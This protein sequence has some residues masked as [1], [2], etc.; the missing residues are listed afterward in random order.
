MEPLSYG[1]EGRGFL[2]PD[3]VELSVDT[4]SRS[5]N[6]VKDWNLN[7][8]CDVDK[9]ICGPSQEI[10]ESTGFLESGIADIFKKSAASN[11]C[12]GALSGEIGNG[13]M[14]ELGAMFNRSATKSCNPMSLPIGLKLD[15][16]TDYG[17]VRTS[18]SSKESSVLSSPESSLPTGE[19]AKR[20][21]L[22]SQFP[23]S[24]VRGQKEDESIAYR[25]VKSNQSL[26]R[27]SALSSVNSSLQGKRLRT[28][29]L[30]SEVPF[31][32]VHGC[33][34][35]LSSSKD[36]HKRHKVCDEHSKTA[37]VIVN[38]IEQR[39]C[40]QCSRF[41]LLAEFDEGKRSCRKRL[42]G[43]NERRR[44]PQFD[45]H[46]GS[47][48]LDMTQRRV[49][50]LFPEILPGSFFYQENYEVNNNNQHLKLERKPFCISQLAMSVT[51]G[52]S[53]AESIQHQYGV[54]KQ[55]L[56]KVPVGSTLLSVQE[57]SAGQNSSCA[58]SL[59]SAHSQN[60]LRN[61]TGISPTPLWMVKGDDHAYIKDDHHNLAKSPSI[62]VPEMQRDGHD[63]GANSM[64]SKNCLS[65]VGGPTMDLVQLSSH[66]L[67]VEQQKNSV[68]VKQEND[69]FSSFAS[70]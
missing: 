19:A 32:Q 46:W 9:P 59:L 42:A 14:L 63:Q 51:S 69:I 52:Q 40:Q 22:H 18:Q 33:N 34:K 68:Q 65:P 28:T 30:H 23:I 39:F 6:T 37:I 8:F 10:T 25:E 67:R 15:E 45:T 24:Q 43:H 2:F 60:L 29:N 54:R 4:F 44:K 13:S 47:R 64:N 62:S 31:C 57:F 66:L 26:K 5:R 53:P 35:D 11:P 48:F 27:N 41:H 20:K 49:P 56:S 38:G 17:E 7:P 58:L 36:Y 16:L 61:S 70:T 50:F 12:P 1:L 55:D 3:N 21:S